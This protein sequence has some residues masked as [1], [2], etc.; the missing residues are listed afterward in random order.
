MLYYPL[1]RSILAFFTL[2]NLFKIQKHENSMIKRLILFILIFAHIATAATIQGTI[3]DLEFNPVKN[4]VIEIDTT[5]KQTIITTDG[6]YSISLAPGEY[7]IRIQHFEDSILIEGLE[8]SITIKD[9]GAYVLDFILF[10]TIDEEIPSGEDTDTIPTKINAFPW[11]LVGVLALILLF[12]LYKKTKKPKEEEKKVVEIEDDLQNM[13]N[14]IKENEGRITQKEL[15]KKINASE[16][17][18]SLMIADLESKGTIRKIKK[19]R[20][21]IIILEKH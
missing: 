2:D 18:I 21:N 8:E 20:G 19:G 12:I 14:I 4:S 11:I 1:N 16:A 5:P 9:E 15:R 7:E 3:Y 17:K 13:I 6:T 10:P